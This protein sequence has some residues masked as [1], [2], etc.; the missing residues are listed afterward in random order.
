MRLWEG[1]TLIFFVFLALAAALSRPRPA[2]VYELFA[3]VTAGLLLVC[4]AAAVPYHA[5]LHDWVVPPLALLLA[6][7]TS[8]LLFVQPREGQERALLGFDRRLGILAH[9]RRMPWLLRTILELAYVGVYPLIPI[10]LALH[11]LCAPQPDPD[12]FWSVVLITDYVCFAVL[13]W[14]Q[15]RPPRVLER[16]EPWSGVVRKFNLRMLGA[17]SI[18]V[19]TFPSGHAAEGLAAALLVIGAPWPAVLWVFAAAL[20]VSAGAVYGRYHYAA[21]AL[22]GWLVAVVVWAVLT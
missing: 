12:R 11:L 19:N 7:W 21:D 2:R 17:A 8:G 15:T 1:A 13:A 5:I 10:A 16:E 4:L 14:V 22:A 9:A 20:A 6:Y 3:G 18:Q